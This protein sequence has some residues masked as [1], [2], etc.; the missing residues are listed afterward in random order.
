M[1]KTKIIAKRVTLSYGP[2]IALYISLFLFIAF[3]TFEFSL[4]STLN[5]NS[6]SI[7]LLTF[8]IVGVLLEAV[9]TI[10]FVCNIRKIKINNSLAKNVITYNNNVFTINTPYESIKVNKSKITRIVYQLKKFCN[11]GT[12]FICYLEKQE[13]LI[14][15]KNVV[16][17]QFVQKEMEQISGLNIID[18]K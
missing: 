5:E 13:M 2:S 18:W 11:Y 10:L 3:L 12:L 16:A 8:I 7:L 6:K 9:L 17:P 14:T 4:L 1:N 15:L